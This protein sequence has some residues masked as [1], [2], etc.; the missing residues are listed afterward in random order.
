VIYGFTHSGR[1]YS[2]LGGY[3]PRL[4][5]LSPGTLMIWWALQAGLERDRLNVF[6]FLRGAEGYKYRW[7][8]RDR[9]NQRLLLRRHAR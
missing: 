7:G 1:F 9:W 6:D 5:P 8:A 4:A 3:G 2:Y